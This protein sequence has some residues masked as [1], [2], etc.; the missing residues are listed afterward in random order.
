M[1]DFLSSPRHTEPKIL[2][3]SLATDTV[4][5]MYSIVKS[6]KASIKKIARFLSSHYK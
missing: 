1:T 4:P 3:N 2:Q 6:E 5:K